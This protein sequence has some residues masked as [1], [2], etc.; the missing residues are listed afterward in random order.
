V[1]DVVQGFAAEFYVGITKKQLDA[2]MAIHPS[3]AKEF[4]TM[5]EPVRQYRDGKLTKGD[6]LKI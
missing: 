6:P 5:T 3:S 1:I 4:V 2:T